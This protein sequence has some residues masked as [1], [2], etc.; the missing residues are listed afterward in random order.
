VKAKATFIEPM[1][2]LRT[3]KLPDDP[4]NWLVELK[5]DG[6]RAI[7]FKSG[8]KIHLRSRN[9]KDFALRYP[10]I[11]KALARLPDETVI[12]GEVVALDEEG[13][14]SFQ[15]LQNY[16][17]APG[18]VVFFIF[19][20]LVLAGVNVMSE[21][22]T[23]RRALL[24]KKILPKLKEPIRYSL[25]FDTPLPDLIAAVKSQGLEGLVAKRRNS[26]Y[27]PGLRSGAW[28]KMRVN[29]GQEFVIGGY[30]VGTSTFDALV[31]GY[32]QGKELL[33]A[34]RTRNGFSPASRAALFKKLK[35]L[36][37]KECP[38]ANLPE[39]KSGRWGAGLTAAKMVDCRWVKPVLVGQFEFV[40]WTGE[41]HLRHSRF[42]AL[43]DDKKATDVVRETT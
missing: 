19:D 26:R 42:I 16:G 10:S 30:T 14:P 11:V 43:R 34:A 3:E 7:A 39:K 21:P 6:Y 22:L 24:Q 2:L 15:V 12:D 28:Q 38:F 25:E 29:A 5:S 9:D 27:E 13:R 41:G 36:E 40:E 17:N 20:L 35:P 37:I 18:P 8:G 1:L 33:Y 23:A 4:V 32:Y 31:F